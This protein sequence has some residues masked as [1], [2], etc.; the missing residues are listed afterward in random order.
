MSLTSES[1]DAQRQISP[2]SA[3]TDRIRFGLI[4]LGRPQR[5]HPRAEA[6]LP[7]RK[8]LP[9]DFTIVHRQGKSLQRRSNVRRPERR[10]EGRRLPPRPSLA[11]A[12]PRRSPEQ[13]RAPRQPLSRAATHSSSL[14]RLPLPVRATS[15]WQSAVVM[16]QPVPL[17]GNTSREP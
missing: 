7:G 4:C 14:A 8:D 10:F 11:T 13:A 5:K 15:S 6:V 2:R 1:A 9:S 12:F 17:R 16:D 3:S